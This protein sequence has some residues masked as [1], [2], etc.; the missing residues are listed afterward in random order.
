MKLLKILLLLLLFVQSIYLAQ[1]ETKLFPSDLLI[2]PFTANTLK[3]KLGFEFK[4]NKNELSLNIGN[5]I[6]ILHHKLN[7]KS[8]FAFG[9]ELFTYTLLRSQSS[10][11]FPVDAVDYLFGFTFG[12]KHKIEKTEL[13]ARLRVS[14][15]SAHFVDGHYDHRNEEWRDGRNPNVYSR[16]FLELMPFYKIKNLRMYFG[17]TYIFSID[18]TN[19]GQDQYQLGFDYFATNLI[20]NHLT[21]YIAYDFRLVNIHEY[22]GN[23]N[24]EAGVKYGFVNGK[25]IS[26]YLKYFSGYSIHGEY[27]DVKEKYTAVGFNFDL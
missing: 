18:P 17:L 16:E 24:I 15:I 6:D 3:P 22:S 13:G 20:S 27:F 5:S 21:P 14:H 8:T 26:L 9:A 23:N 4:T 2:K 10:F 12:Y 7:Q 19:I 1:A 11:H 25:G